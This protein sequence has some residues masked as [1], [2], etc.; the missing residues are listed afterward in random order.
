MSIYKY[1]QCSV[2]VSS[3]SELPFDV[4]SPERH[5]ANLGGLGIHCHFWEEVRCL[6]MSSSELLADSNLLLMAKKR[7]IP[8]VELGSVFSDLLPVGPFDKSDLA[9]DLLGGNALLTLGGLGVDVFLN[10]VMHCNLL[11][12]I[13][14]CSLKNRLVTALPCCSLTA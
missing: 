5:N 9:L 1:I 7:D 3:P 12:A 6:L 10:W 13:S 14:L 11:L 4:N 2:L 8:W